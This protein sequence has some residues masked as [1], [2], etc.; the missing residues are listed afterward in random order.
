MGVRLTILGSGTSHGV[1]MI[2]C[3]CAVCMSD[4]PHDHRTRCSAAFTFND[5]T[6]LI[7]TAPELR[8]QCL[9]NDIRVAHGVAY[10]HHH[11]DHVVGLDDVRR[12]NWLLQA[13]FPVY[14]EAPTMTRLRQM[15]EYAFVNDPT[16]PSAKP[17]LDPRLLDGPFAF[18]GRDVIPIR[19]MHGPLPVV[20]FR[21]G[22]VAYLPDCNQIPSGSRAA[23]ADLDALVLDALRIRP[24]PTHFN[25]EQAVETAEQIGAA[26][27][28][29]THIA[30]E[31]GH[32]ATNASLPTGMQ[33]AYDGLRIE[34]D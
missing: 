12:F 6:L 28:Y 22:A 23:L 21:V 3:E 11:A 5:H 33:L 16:Y 26:R 2:G 15:F 7:D 4:D 20:G 29:F 32:A 18:A 25:L 1:P 31:L 10:T 14:A 24:H 13:A 9:A 17:E 8:L 19:I 34:S 27:T 30:H